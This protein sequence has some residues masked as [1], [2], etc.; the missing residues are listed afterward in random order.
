VNDAN[1]QLPLNKLLPFAGTYG[2]LIIYL[3]KNKLYCK[4]DNNGGAV[5]EL[6]HITNNLFVLDKDAQIEFIKDSKGHYSD[7]KIF[8]NDGTIF[9][10]KRN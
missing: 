4:N 1:S 6:K 5:S 9:E 8:V 2:G 10:E 3:D 7:I